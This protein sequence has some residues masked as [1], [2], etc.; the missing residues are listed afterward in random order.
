MEWTTN[1]LESFRNSY[2]KTRMQIS[3]IIWMFYDINESQS[4]R[5]ILFI[6][7]T[8]G[9]SEIFWLQLKTLKENFRVI[10]VDIPSI[11]DIFEISNSLHSL[12][13]KLEI[14][15]VSLVGTSYGGYLAQA[16][17]SLYPDMISNLVLSNTFITT[18]IYNQKYKLLLDFQRLI[19]TFIL[20]FI[21]K[22]SLNS[23]KHEPTRKYLIN[24]LRSSLEKKVLLARLR[25]FINDYSME[26][27][28]VDSV[29]IIETKNDPLIPFSLQKDLRQVYSEAEVHTF[30]EDT[31]HFPYL[32][33]S[34]VY[35]R[36]LLKI[37]NSN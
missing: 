36:I 17:A 24:Q 31:N 22:K 25:G 13:K 34:E 26:K 32:T 12:L 3:S 8:T 9:S 16:Y 20:K 37:L 35:N 33:Q 18:E 27:V 7:G 29:F 15:S 14:N 11:P 23:I 1:Q 5:T 4:N 6:H 2:P 10:S 19:P 21:M 30:E 28:S